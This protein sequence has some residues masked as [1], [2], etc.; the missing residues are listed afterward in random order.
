M[1]AVGHV[2]WRMGQGIG[3]WDIETLVRIRSAQGRRRRTGKTGR[4]GSGHAQT[5]CCGSGLGGTA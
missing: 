5:R 2:E 1:G 3:A 4:G